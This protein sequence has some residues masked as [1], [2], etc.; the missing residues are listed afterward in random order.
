MQPRC[1]PGGLVD[2]CET[3]PPPY[4]R[5]WEWTGGRAGRSGRSHWP[6]GPSLERKKHTHRAEAVLPTYFLVWRLTISVIAYTGRAS[7]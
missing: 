1:G 5:G 6:A 4:P 7:L 3:E 2:S